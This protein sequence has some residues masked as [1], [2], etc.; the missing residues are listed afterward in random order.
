MKIIAYIGKEIKIIKK[1]KSFNAKKPKKMLTKAVNGIYG[2]EIFISIGRSYD[3]IEA[4]CSSL[5]HPD[6]KYK[7]FPCNFD[8]YLSAHSWVIKIA[9]DMLYNR[10]STVS[11]NSFTEAKYPRCYDWTEENKINEPCQLSIELGF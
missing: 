1:I 6:Y 4:S 11:I 5:Y 7:R 9:E 3:F 2:G 10:L 8:G